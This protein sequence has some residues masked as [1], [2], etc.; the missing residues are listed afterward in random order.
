MKEKI[1]YIDH[2][3]HRKTKSNIFLVEL[4]KERYYVEYITFDPVANKFNCD[5]RVLEEEFDS[6]IL[7]QVIVNME[8]LKKVFHY[9]NLIFIP[10][11]DGVCSFPDS[12]WMNYKNCNIINFSKTLHEKLQKFGLSTNYIQFF[13][14]PLECNEGGE[15]QVYFWQRTQSINL[16]KILCLLENYDIEKV[17]IHAVSDPGSYIDRPSEELIRK[18]N[19][20]YSDWYESKEDMLNDEKNYAFYVA[21]RECEGIG[22]SFLEAMAMGKV[23]IAVD[24][25]TMNEYIESGKTG[26]LFDNKNIN[27]IE[28]K[29][30]QQIQKNV[31]EYICK[32]F[33]EWQERKYD[34]LKWVLEKPHVN[35]ELYNRK[36]GDTTIIS[37]HFLFHM[38][39]LTYEKGNT[40]RLFG[41]LK[42]PEAIADILFKIYF[43]IKKEPKK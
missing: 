33:Q 39:I 4:L 26:F 28:K 6:L 3:F 21:P 34:I 1:L 24:A 31:Y 30:I 15:K 10:M 7:F 5:K 8:N 43:K 35:E 17:H 16:E 20:E 14:E 25:P 32:G 27:P 29:E 42:V 12:F 22:M 19:I 23:V 41:K 36:F 37:K 9:N 2:E 18:Y 40:Y 13:P 38:L 11:Y